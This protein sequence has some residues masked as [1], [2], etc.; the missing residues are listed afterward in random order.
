MRSSVI[1]GGLGVSGVGSK[2]HPARLLYPR[3]GSDLA[4]S[5]LRVRGG[6]V[7]FLATA[8]STMFNSSETGHRL[9]PPLLRVPRRF[10]TA[11]FAAL[12]AAPSEDPR[13]NMELA[14][15]DHCRLAVGEFALRVCRCASLGPQGMI[16]SC[17]AIKKPEP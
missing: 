2:L 14:T 15:W 9:F 5:L 12:T 7:A 4:G 8:P 10:A 13:C 17:R 1:S 6:L 16:E 3:E 11:A